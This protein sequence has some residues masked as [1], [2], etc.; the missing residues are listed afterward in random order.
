MLIDTH[1]HLD[2]PQFDKDR[3][4]IIKELK[5]LEIRVI[6]VGSHQQS[7][8]DSIALAKKHQNIYAAVGIHPHDAEK[9]KD[10]PN[11]EKHLQTLNG[12]TASNKT[13]IAVN[14]ILAVLALMLSSGALGLSKLIGIW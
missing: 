5:R 2:F 14:R 12:T 3:E 9:V 13:Q 1:A 10:I 4:K 11:I 8:L 6:N 7:C